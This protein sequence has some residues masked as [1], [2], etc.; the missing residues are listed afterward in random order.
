MKRL[1]LV[2]IASLLL[3]G[4]G[5]SLFDFADIECHKF[6]PEPIGYP[7]RICAVTFDDKG[8]IGKLLN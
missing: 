4:V 1:G 3:V 8:I 6:E 5:E 2:L 7:V